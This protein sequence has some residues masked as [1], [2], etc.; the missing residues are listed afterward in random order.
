MLVSSRAQRLIYLKVSTTQTRSKKSLSNVHSWKFT[1]SQ[2]T[3]LLSVPSRIRCALQLLSCD[4][5]DLSS[6]NIRDLLNPKNTSLRI[7]ET[8]AGELLVQGLL[9]EYC[10]G[11]EDILKLIELGEKSRSVASTDVCDMCPALF[12]TCFIALHANG[13]LCVSDNDRVVCKLSCLDE[14]CEFALAQCA[15]CGRHSE[16]EGW[17]YSCMGAAASLC[18]HTAPRSV[19]TPQVCVRLL[20]GRRL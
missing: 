13:R 3:L 12:S 10:A 5:C 7:R 16:A 2:S 11:E 6:E 19:A 20:V 17:Q 8:P 18:P 4:L 14:R 1:G 15:D 9:E